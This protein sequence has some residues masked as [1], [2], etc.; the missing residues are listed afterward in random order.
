VRARELKKKES[1]MELEVP[2][3]AK[4]VASLISKDKDKER[5]KD[6]DQ[7]VII[8]E[9]SSKEEDRIEVLLGLFRRNKKKAVLM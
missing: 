9:K 3:T 8:E 5:E 6:R 2:G 1:E 7:P 4:R